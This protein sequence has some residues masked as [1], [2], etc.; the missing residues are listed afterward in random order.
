MLKSFKVIFLVL[1]IFI[2]ANKNI[3]AQFAGGSG[4]E[5]DPYLVETADHLNNVREFLDSQF[6]QIMDIN[7]DIAPYNIGEGWVPI[8]STNNY[9]TGIYDGQDY[10]IT[11]LYINRPDEPGMGLF[12]STSNSSEI[13]NLG[14]E[15][16][17]ITGYS[18]VG[19]LVTWNQATI[20]NC[21]TSGSVTGDYLYTG[22]LVA[23]HVDNNITNCFSSCDVT[24]NVQV[25][26]LVGGSG[27]IIES[28]YSSG[29]V[30][31]NG[32]VGG[33]VGS[34]NNIIINCY[35]TGNVYGVNDRIGGLV[36][37]MQGSIIDSYCTGDVTGTLQV[38][39][40][41]G[42][43]WFGPISNSYYNYE[44]VLINGVG[45]VITVGALGED[46]FTE[47]LDSSLMLDIN[48]YLEFVEGS[49]A[50]YNIN[51]FKK[52]LAFGYNSA[53]SYKLYTDIDMNSE[54]NFYIPYLMGDFNGN[55]HIIENLNVNMPG[56][57]D[58]GLFGFVGYDAEIS[59]LG[60]NNLSIIGDRYIGGLIGSNAGTI[61]SCYTTGSVVG[62]MKVGGLVGHNFETIS[63]SYSKCS[64]VGDTYAGGLVGDN[65][66][67]SIEFSYS[68]GNVT[69][70]SSF[71]GFVGNNY[72]GSVNF[73]YWNT[74][75]SGQSS[76]PGGEGRT[77]EEMTYPYA[78]NTFIDWDFEDIWQ[79]DEEYIN[80]GYPYLLNL[81]VGINYNNI[82][83]FC[84]TLNNF[85]NPFN[86]TTTI[87]FSI[88]DETKVDL[89]I[90]NIK[91]Q[92][93]KSLLNDQIEAGEH[94]IV[95]NGEDASGKKVA[96]GIYFYKLKTQTKTHIKKMLLLK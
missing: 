16:V 15:N 34:N 64:V 80:N 93:I 13:S 44:S 83:P 32:T 14:V 89:S 6:K 48:N 26:G 40:L 22:G 12:N 8:G 94:S 75:S 51:D 59:N 90:Y 52:L 91:G 74:E 33:L 39:G 85:P 5:E 92:K 82:T 55:D 35:S 27:S 88:P 70:N 84:C 56:F 31:G 87:S 3:Y 17:D 49:Y 58:I 61:F 11:N 86:P 24:G 63:N 68:T 4:T 54:P 79:E 2:I 41:V 7:L 57:D 25:G 95:W 53:Y 20:N 76:S 28:C 46:H 29:S 45:S 78:A 38:G 42:W 77:T 66:Y 67:S 9:F 36:G 18:H 23:C 81:A 37:A 47:W 71:G 50:I 10:T 21:H 43:S 72:S 1:T 19:A 30:E 73:C 65:S 60:I 69:G 62:Y 96:S